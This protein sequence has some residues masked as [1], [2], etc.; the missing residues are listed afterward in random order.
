MS[1]ESPGA[2]GWVTVAFLCGAAALSAML[3][4][5]FLSEFYAGT[6]IIPVTIVAAMVGNVLL[7][8]LGLRALGRTAGAVLPLLCWL[9]PVLVLTM[10]NRPEGDLF[11]IAEYQQQYAF[12]G[13]LLGGSAAGLATVVL[14]GG[15]A[16]AR[17]NPPVRPAPQR[18]P[19]AARQSSSTRRPSA[20]KRPPVSR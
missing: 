9:I 18:R 16:S 5:A 20:G 2:A 14:A 13:L 3:E 1:D 17:R 11:V 19:P 10:Y 12:Y 4:L 15:N 6:V 7:P 8:M